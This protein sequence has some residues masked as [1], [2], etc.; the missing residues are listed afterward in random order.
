MDN[1]LLM[2]QQQVQEQQQQ[3][4]RY[5]VARQN[6][7]PGPGEI[8]KHMDKVG[9]P[10]VYEAINA[11]M[12]NAYRA[13]LERSQ[14]DGVVLDVLPLHS[15]RG[16]RFMEAGY[17]VLEFHMAGS[18]YDQ[19]PAMHRR[20]SGLRQYTTLKKLEKCLWQALP[21]AVMAGAMLFYYYDINQIAEYLINLFPDVFDF[22]QL[23]TEEIE[24]LGRRDEETADTTGEVVSIDN[25][26]Y[27]FIRRSVKI[28]Q[29]NERT[30]SKTRYTIAGPCELNVMG[31]YTTKASRKH[32]LQ[33]ASSYLQ[34]KFQASRPAQISPI[35]IKIMGFSRGGVTAS[36]GAMMIRRWV[37][38]NYADYADKVHFDLIQFDPVAGGDTGYAVSQEVNY[39]LGTKADEQGKF[40]SGGI[41]Y[42]A[43]RDSAQT[44][45][46]YSMQTEYGLLGFT[47]QVVKGVDRI[48]VTPFEHSVGLDKVDKNQVLSKEGTITTD[49]H[50]LAFIDAATES[51][52]RLG[53]LNELEKG[54]YIL[55]EKNILVKIGS[56]V[57]YKTIMDKLYAK[58]KGL[59]QGQPSQES[60][61]NA[62]SSAVRYWFKENGESG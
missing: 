8:T 15:K 14:R 39:K 52:Y 20:I 62:I 26:Q 2:E 61:H 41:E 56:A 4:E 7:C 48:I 1:N 47:P 5:L 3:Q 45:V 28:S 46:V 19:L 43:L 31:D 36:E 37:L 49:E 60:R 59:L 51:A 21:F 32:M 30:Q 23:K 13:V 42:A 16:T 50:R 12:A 18:T 22:Q 25:K 9:I 58:F 44:T 24:A 17:D 53:A 57:Q 38:D 10:S 29:V 35:V 34:P 27:Q 54:V 11:V 33:L 6:L 40:K 55:D